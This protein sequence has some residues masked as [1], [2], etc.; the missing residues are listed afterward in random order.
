[1]WASKRFSFDSIGVEGSFFIPQIPSLDTS[2]VPIYDA[3]ECL[4]YTARGALRARLRFTKEFDH[5][6]YGTIREA[7]RDQMYV[8]VKQ[9]RSTDS[10][11]LQEALLQ[12][13]AH[14]V[15]HSEGIPWAVPTVYDVFRNGSETWFSMERIYGYSIPGWFTQPSHKDLDALFLIAQVSLILAT[16]E[17]ALNLDHRDLKMNNLMIRHEACLLKVKIHD[18]TWSLTCPFQVVVLDFGFA[19][20]GSEP[21]RGKPLVNLGDGLLP[22]MD[23]CPKEGRDLFHF[24]VSLLGVPVFRTAISQR[25]HDKLDGWL[26]IGK[27]SYGP[28]ARRWSKENWSYLVSSQASFSIPSCCPVQILHDLLPELRGSLSLSKTMV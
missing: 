19:C 7:I 27:K 24:L 11:L 13:L 12:Q 22:P 1:M 28:L 23:P 26:S 16:L 21:L 14:T 20:L 2:R 8:L 4:L 17:T 3:S 9:P 6:S 18:I 5:G 15:L 25:L 10:S